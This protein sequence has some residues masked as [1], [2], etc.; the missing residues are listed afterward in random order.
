MPENLIY[1]DK[2][3]DMIVRFRCNNCQYVGEA[4]EIGQGIM[5]PQCQEK[6]N[7]VVIFNNYQEIDMARKG[8]LP[9]NLYGLVILIGLVMFLA[10]KLLPFIFFMPIFVALMVAEVLII[11]KGTKK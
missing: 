3:P 4:A 9:A 6:H 5:C 10:Y 8:K 1:P 2:I 7:L 11:L